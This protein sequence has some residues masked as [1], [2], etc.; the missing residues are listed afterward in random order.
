[1]ECPN[2]QGMVSKKWKACPACGVN[3][4]TG[5]FNSEVDDDPV[6]AI[7]KLQERQDKMDEYLTDKAIEEGAFDPDENDD[8]E[9]PKGKVKPAKKSVSKKRRTLF[10]D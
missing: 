4:K 2:C 1:M 3:I 9:K 6:D 5:K 8:E 10:G 7:K